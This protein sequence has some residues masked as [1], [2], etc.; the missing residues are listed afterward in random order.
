MKPDPQNTV[1]PFSLHACIFMSRSCN[2]ASGPFEHLFCG[3]V[4]G[5]AEVLYK[6]NR[7]GSDFSARVFIFFKEGIQRFTTTIAAYFICFSFGLLIAEKS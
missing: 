5:F 6:L 4:M 7:S 1:A 2:G 3:Y